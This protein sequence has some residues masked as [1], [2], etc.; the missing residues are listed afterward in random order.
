MYRNKIIGPDKIGI[1]LVKILGK[2]RID[3]I[4]VLINNIYE[5]GK[6]SA[7]RNNSIFIPIPKTATCIFGKGG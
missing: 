2:E 7:E 1:E 6:I 4:N 5:T 3:I